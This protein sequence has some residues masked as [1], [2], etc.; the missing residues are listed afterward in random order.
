MWAVNAS[1][2]PELSFLL[3]DVETGT[4]AGIVLTVCW[5]AETSATGIRDSHLRV[6]G[7]RPAYRRRG[8]AHALISHTLRAAQDQGYGRASL[9]V[10]ADNPSGGFGF[11]ERAGFVTH[12]TQ[13]H[14]CIGL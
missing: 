2:R 6:I 4:S 3:R 7:T 8:V 11:A 9:R 1:F 13:V 5:E 14:Y 10:A 12:D